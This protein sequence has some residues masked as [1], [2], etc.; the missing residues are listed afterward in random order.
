MESE[1]EVTYMQAEV[2]ANVVNSKLV[3]ADSEAACVEV[4][5]DVEK[6][7]LSMVPGGGNDHFAKGTSDL[8]HVF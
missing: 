3:E 4:E 2:K 8:V 7:L 5:A 6:N 1:A